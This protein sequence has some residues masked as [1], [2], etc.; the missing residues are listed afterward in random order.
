MDLI[1]AISR[2]SP[3]SAES[4]KHFGELVLERHFKAGEKLLELGVIDRE[5]H[6]IKQGSGRVFYLLD[7]KDVT[8]YFAMDGEFLG[9]VAS[10]FTGTASQKGI[11]LV[12]N[13]IVESFNYSL[14]EELS[15]RYHDLETAGRKLATFAFLECQR[16]IES[17]RFCSAAQRYHQLEERYPGISNRVPLKHIAS[18]LGTTQVSLSRIRKGIQ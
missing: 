16:R 15:G 9:G 10:L 5:F 8:D 18:Y 7:G 12:E 13:S 4:Q 6:F 14:F 1:T 17:I 2:I 11:E 3:L